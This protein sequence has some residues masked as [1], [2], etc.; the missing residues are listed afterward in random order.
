MIIYCFLL[1]GITS[2]IR[3]VNIV[4]V[5]FLPKQ[6]WHSNISGIKSEPFNTGSKVPS[7]GSR[8]KS[9]R[10]KNELVEL[11]LFIP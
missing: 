2:Q 9:S 3:L 1:R 11:S 4:P 8:L 6:D 10:S 5:G 7:P